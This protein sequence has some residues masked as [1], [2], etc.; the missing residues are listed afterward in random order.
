VDEADPLNG[1]DDVT[2]ALWM[3]KDQ[4]AFSLTK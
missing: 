4:R 2:I 1:C 3:G